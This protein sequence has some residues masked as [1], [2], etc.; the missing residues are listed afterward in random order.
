MAFS[1]YSFFKKHFQLLTDIYIKIS[2]AW[3]QSGELH[4]SVKKQVMLIK[5]SG[6]YNGKKC[7]LAEFKL[8]HTSCGSY[9]IGFG[10][11]SR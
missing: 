7:N 6:S 10:C 5:R 4:T 1:I 3:T 9:D 8:P 11:C 2:P